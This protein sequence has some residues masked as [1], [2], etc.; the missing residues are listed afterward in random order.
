MPR[1]TSVVLSILCTLAGAGCA[2]RASEPGLLGDAALKAY[3]AKPFDKHA[4][5]GQTVELGRNH[6]LPVVVEFP[7]ADVCPQ[8]TVRIIHYR[9]PAGA[10]CAAAGGVTKSVAVPVAI[11]VMQKTFC[12]PAALAADGGYYTR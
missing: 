10:D 7:C 5:M 4:M 8:Y 9:L 3:A 6:G 2:T 11:T 1:I 12:I